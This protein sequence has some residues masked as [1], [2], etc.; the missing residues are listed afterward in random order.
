MGWKAEYFTPGRHLALE[1]NVLFV[2]THH[3]ARS[4][5]AAALFN[6]LTGASSQHRVRSVGLASGAN[7]RLTTRELAWAN[8]VVVMEP[9]HQTLI[10]RRWP[11]HTAK[12]RLLDVPDDYE[13]DEPALRALLIPKL[14]ALLA[15]L[16]AVPLRR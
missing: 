15:A 7:R 16:D 4:P 5:M 6:E 1:M 11:Q 10:A 2:C 12:V 13:P 3:V 9:V 14:H 8:V